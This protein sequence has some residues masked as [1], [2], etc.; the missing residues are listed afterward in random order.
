MR[1]SD[2]SLLLSFATHRDEAAFRQL[3]ERHMGLIYH[4]PLRRTA[5]RQLA[6]EVSQNI[7]CALAKKAASLAKNPDLLPAWLHRA[8]VFE[9]S[10][11]MRSEI[12]RQRRALLQDPAE[13]ASTG[14]GDSQ[15]STWAEALPH[16]DLVLDKLS[17]A[18]RTVIL[19]HYF[20]NRP[21]P[22]IAKTLGKNTAAVQKQAQR[23]LSKL[24]RLLRSRGVA[25]PATAIAS[26]LAT[27]LA[28]AAPPAFL[29]S[30][31]AAVLTGSVEF[32]TTG[33]TLMTLTKSKALVPLLILI[34]AL[35]LAW[36]QM[37]I[38]RAWSRNDQL[39]AHL[40]PPRDID[41]S[42]PATGRD[43]TNP[44]GT[45][46]SSNID[47]L[48]LLDEQ[49]EAIRVGGLRYEAFHAKLRGLGNEVLVRL[50]GEAATL[51]ANR[52]DKDALLNSLLAAIAT[53]DPALA[54]TT[55]VA[56]FGNGT[57]FLQQLGRSEAPRHFATWARKDLL[58]AKVW[59]DEQEKSGKF[60]LPGSPDHFTSRSALNGF[61][62]GL[63]AAMVFANSPDT[64]AYL[65]A[66]PLDERFYLI[67]GSIGAADRGT[68]PPGGDFAGYLTV[69]REQ[70]PGKEHDEALKNL[71]G[72]LSDLSG[73][74]PE[75]SALLVAGQATP[76]EREIIVRASVMKVLGAGRM[77]P[78][79][80][81]DARILAETRDW[82]RQ[83]IPAKTNEILREGMELATQNKIR[84][85][86][87]KI[88][89]LRAL[90]EPSDESLV[91]TLSRE[92]FTP[93]LSEA[94]ELAAKIKDPV[95]RAA[96]IQTLNS[97]QPPA[98]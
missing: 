13:L 95:R 30:A 42:A 33:I 3:A 27:G 41:E 72:A 70:L 18:E 50:V 61:K 7:L 55:A 83:E 12:S 75:V 89:E 94:L 66:M 1:E 17:A 54:V 91:V 4:T 77:P 38:S 20:E 29:Q 73:G 74:S 60:Q 36:Q 57:S 48:V 86:D 39:R 5:H 62:T 92:D 79:L 26:G 28:R 53:R 15:T 21:F 85:A 22:A 82:L 16:L 14:T 93:R 35:P 45:G 68:T 98:K 19:Q 46:I 69:I 44:R 63:I 51:R 84:R 56:S 2:E 76:A 32:S 10:K 9:S 37:A 47:I 87:L 97:Q 81:R 80:A 8:T 6:E 11:A 90:A 49:R 67:N 40:G 78:D 64:A 88:Q 58:A 31:T 59:L 25:L 96:V 65:S 71:A 24:G 52:E 43:R 23:A 34:L